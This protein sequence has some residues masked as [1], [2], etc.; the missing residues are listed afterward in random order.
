MNQNQL[1][2]WLADDDEDDCIFFKEALEEL[3]I[4]STLVTVNN[5]DE[6]M[7]ALITKSAPLPDVLF[8]DLNMPRKTGFE[9]LTE[10][11]LNQN[12]KSLP[13]IIYSTSLDMEVVNL[14]YEKGAHHYI[15]KPGEFSELKKVI[16]EVL[17]V[18]VKTNSVR[19]TKEKFVI[20]V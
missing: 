16:L 12:L 15:R 3:P 4:D 6:L 19:P 20:Q 14:L 7:H 10:I 17:T 8:L 18:T 2:L 11:K 13:V 5:G 1:N 9:C